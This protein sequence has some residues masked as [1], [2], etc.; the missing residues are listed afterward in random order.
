MKT[1]AIIPAAGNGSRLRSEKIKPFIEISGRSIISLTLEVFEASDSIDSVVLVVPLEKMSEFESVIQAQR[2]SKVNRIVAGGRSRRESVYNGLQVLDQDTQIVVVHDA[3]RPLLE[4]DMLEKAVR[5][6]HEKEAVV[7]G[8][9]VKPTLKRVNSESM[10]VS[11]TVERGSLWEAQTPQVFRKDVLVKAHENEPGF[12]ASDDA[13]LVERIG[14]GITMLEGSYRNIKITTA[15]DL[16]IA[17]AFL[18][19]RVSL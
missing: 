6:A 2:F 10:L 12:D 14:I 17:N 16:I 15:E 4:K 11:E 19:E 1:Q 5:A 9:P 8:V 18:S 13:L 3:A 7:V